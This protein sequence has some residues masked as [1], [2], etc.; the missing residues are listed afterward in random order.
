MSA[1]YEDHKASFEEL[2]ELD[3]GVSVHYKYF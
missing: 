1:C 3:N 2:L